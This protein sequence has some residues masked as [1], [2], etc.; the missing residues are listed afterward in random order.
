MAGV[1]LCVAACCSES[2]QLKPHVYTKYLED[3]DVTFAAV[4]SQCNTLQHAET[5]CNT[6]QHSARGVIVVS[7]VSG[8]GEVCMAYT[9]VLVN[10]LDPKHVLRYVY[11]Y[12]SVD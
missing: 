12:C 2:Y 11:E 6:L 3:G 4:S 9:S 8:G 1:L 10:L 5:H 7:I